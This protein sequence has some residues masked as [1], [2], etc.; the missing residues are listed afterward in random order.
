MKLAQDL[1]LKMRMRKAM[2]SKTSAAQKRLNPTIRALFTIIQPQ[3][4]NSDL[5]LKLMLSE[6]QSKEQCLQYKKKE[7]LL[8]I[9]QTVTFHHLII[10]LTLDQSLQV[11]L[12]KILQTCFLTLNLNLQHRM[13]RKLGFPSLICQ[14][15]KMIIDHNQFL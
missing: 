2:K 14:W 11:L 5:R 9:H 3:I 15:M 4:L 7:N 13:F 10:L 6:F 8:K 12:L 1:L